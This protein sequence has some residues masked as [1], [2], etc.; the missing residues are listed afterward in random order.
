MDAKS[1]Y[2]Q[3]V[4]HGPDSLESFKDLRSALEYADT[5]PSEALA[6]RARHESAQREAESKKLLKETWLAQGGDATEFERQHQKH[7]DEHAGQRLRDLD[8]ETRLSFARS[9]VRGF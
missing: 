5:H 4:G 7:Q 8:D 2:E 9:I 6:I 1:A 3:Y